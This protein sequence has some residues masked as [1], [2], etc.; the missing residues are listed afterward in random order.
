MDNDGLIELDGNGY[1]KWENLPMR[2]T[3]LHTTHYD[4][5]PDCKDKMNPPITLPAVVS[6]WRFEFLTHST[7][8]RSTSQF[9]DFVSFGMSVR[10]LFQCSKMQ[11]IAAVKAK[12][13]PKSQVLGLG[14][15]QH[16]GSNS[17]A[18]FQQEHLE[19]S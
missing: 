4:C 5:D 2:R 12:Y 3:H 9:L 14:L 15:S 13:K 6:S 11:D 19:F 1:Q 8:A 10:F 7:D 16:I 17:R 18:A